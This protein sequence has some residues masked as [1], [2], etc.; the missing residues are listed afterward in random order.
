M[1]GLLGRSVSTRVVAPA[2]DH[3]GKDPDHPERH[4]ENPGVVKDS[5]VIVVRVS[6]GRV[7]PQDG[8]ARQIPLR[9]RTMETLASGDRWPPRGWSGRMTPRVNPSIL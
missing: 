8:L 6:V 9:D 7:R 1:D 4:P 2:P 3:D 5:E